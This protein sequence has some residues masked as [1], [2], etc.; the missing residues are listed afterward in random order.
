MHIPALQLAGVMIMLAHAQISFWLIALHN[1]TVFINFFRGRNPT[2]FHDDQN[3]N[4]WRA[5]VLAEVPGPGN[6][7]RLVDISVHNS[8]A[9]WHAIRTANIR[10]HQ[11]GTGSLV[12]I[13]NAP[14]T[15][16]GVPRVHR[17]CLHY[18]RAPPAKG[19]YTL[20]LVRAT[21]RY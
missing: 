9:L 3:H 13:L 14:A 6:R 1:P 15:F 10:S 16:M 4:V 19:S 5:T 2:V 18:M 8:P 20:N 7:L 11:P 21:Q 17:V 12:L